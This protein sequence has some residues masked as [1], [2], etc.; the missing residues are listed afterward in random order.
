MRFF[1]TTGISRRGMDHAGS[2]AV[3]I[4][5]A[6]RPPMQPSRRSRHACSLSIFYCCCASACCSRQVAPCG[7]AGRHV[8]PKAAARSESSLP[9]PPLCARCNVSHAES[10]ALDR[11][12]RPSNS[13]VR[14]EAFLGVEDGTRRQPAAAL[15]LAANGALT[16][17]A[18]GSDQGAAATSGSLCGP[19]LAWNGKDRRRFS[20]IADC[21]RDGCVLAHDLHEGLAAL[22]QRY[23]DRRISAARSHPRDRTP[24][25][26]SNA[27]PSCLLSHGWSVTLDDSASRR[28]LKRTDQAEAAHEWPQAD[29]EELARLEALVEQTL[30]GVFARSSRVLYQDK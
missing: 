29:R 22:N 28:T 14:K 6:S 18:A 9:P 15:H 21:R 10:S 8:E 27:T 5:S 19:T 17:A 25:C 13:G 23:V 30:K 4:L 12:R 20:L 11:D 3:G 7:L 1:L 16:M 26:T 2:G 24:G